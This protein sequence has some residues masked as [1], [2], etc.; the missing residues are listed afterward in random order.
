MPQLVRW[1]CF[2]F[3][4]LMAVVVEAATLHVIIV[5]DIDAQDIRQSVEV[6]VVNVS[7]KL[8][9]SALSSGMA[10]NEKIFMGENIQPNILDVIDQFVVEPDDTVFFY[11]S[12]HG[13]RTYAKAEN[14]WPN[15]Y[16]S[17]LDAGIDLLDVVKIVEKKNPRLLIAVADCCNNFLPIRK[18]PPVIRLPGHALMVRVPGVKNNFTQLFLH[19]RGKIIVSSSTPGQVSSGT[20]YGGVYTYYFLNSLEE[21]VHSFYK[22][23]WQVI[24]DRTAGHVIKFDSEQVPQYEL[25]LIPRSS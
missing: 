3:F 23:D 17:L 11:F 13:Y 25:N 7:K 24:L 15:L 5:C 9:Q 20:S 10:Y 18:A 19:T 14:P 21:E 8:Q 4:L 16:L 1:S 2:V 12:G 22:P 6:D